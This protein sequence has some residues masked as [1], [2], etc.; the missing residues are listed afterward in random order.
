M[1][2]KRLASRV[3]LDH[4][5]LKVIEDTI[6]LP[7]GHRTDYVYFGNA[8]DAVVIIALNDK[9]QVLLL[10]EYS[11]PIHEYMLQFPG[12]GVKSGEAPEQGA[13]RELAEEGELTGMF[14]QLGWY[15]P[16]NRRNPK[17]M[18][19]FVATDLR[20]ASAPK[21]VEEAFESFWHTPA[22]INTMIRGNQ[23]HNYATLGAWSFFTNSR[24]YLA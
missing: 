5:R 7:S 23:L 18:Y 2:W 21:D 9:G 22:E 11:Y 13:A 8:A 10:R 24:F 12:G 19:V 4:P 16:D 1:P 14:E 15:Y 6:E 17:R 20:Q 3:I